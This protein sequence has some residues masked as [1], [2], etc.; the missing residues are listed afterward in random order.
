MLFPFRSVAMGVTT[1]NDGDA[2]KL[3]KVQLV[4]LFPFG[5]TNSQ[6]F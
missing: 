1:C 5:W 2:K 3:T 4:C 6:I